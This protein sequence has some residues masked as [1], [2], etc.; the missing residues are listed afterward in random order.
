MKFGGFYEH[1][2]PR[3][4]VAE[5]EHTLIKNALEQAVLSDQ[6]GYDYVW[7]TEHHF[8]E[9]YAHSSA[10]EVFLA[11]CS[12]RTK[13]IRIGHGIVQTPPYIN[14]PARVAERIAT[15]D[16]ISDGR[17]EFGTGAGATET[18]LGG[19]LV[20]QSEKKDMQLEGMRVALRL[21]VEE[22]FTG[23]EGK[24]VKMP[25]RNLAPKPYQK[26]HP[27]LW[28]ACSRRESI[29]QAA[30]L[31]MGALTFSFVSPEE[32]QHWVKDYYEVIENECEPIG[33]AVNP[34]FAVAAPFLCDRD[35][36]RVAAIGMESYGFFIYGLGHYSFFGEHRPGHTDIW[37]EYKT[38]P[39]EFAP[40]EGRI[41]D[42]VGTPQMLRQRL[43]D[44]EQ[45]GID[46]VLCISQAGKI[47][48]DLLCSS[49]RLFSQEVLPEF[50][51]RDLA[52]ARQR[53][54]QRARINE[55][56]LARKPKVEAA[57]Q[58]EFVIRAAGHH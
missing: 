4:W 21:L 46:Q 9:E 56:A 7:A 13:N 17:C 23:Y 32:A 49:I 42:C 58:T 5:S 10:P 15:L 14:H 39:K 37:H 24:Y 20:P 25:P 34:N 41:Q 48:H 8:L 22:P 1:Q 31:G 57:A 40:P 29:I 36:K 28:M 30:K 26:P 51:D 19:F 27:P 47:P 38:N 50:K 45:A 35:E 6:C 2:L 3:P 16:L 44:F 43:R 12:Q 33:Y 53:D 55:R 18:E 52:K 11:A 54:E